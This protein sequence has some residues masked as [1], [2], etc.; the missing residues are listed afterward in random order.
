M[1]AG[2]MLFEIPGKETMKEHQGSKRETKKIQV[3]SNDIQ[4]KA[5]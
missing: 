2:N 5:G 4:Q 3:D 1:K